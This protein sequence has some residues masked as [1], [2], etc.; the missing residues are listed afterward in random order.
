MHP[1]VKDWNLS[2]GCRRIKASGGLSKTGDLKQE[3][4]LRALTKYHLTK[5]LRFLFEM[6]VSKEVV[7]SIAF[8]SEGLESL[9]R[10]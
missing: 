5:N 9:G 4:P 3:I 10:L 2:E 7:V 8:R 1:G 6:K